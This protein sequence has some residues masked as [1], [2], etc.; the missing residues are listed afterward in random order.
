MGILTRATR[1]LSRRKTRALIVIIA[2]SLALTMLIILPPSITARQELT[3]QAINGLIGS[4]NALKSTVTLSATEIQCG[5]PISFDPSMAIGSSGSTIWLTQPLM[6]DSL[7]ANIS[8]IPDVNNV[9]P[10]LFE[11]ST[12]NRSYGIYGV[13]LDNASF[14]MDPSILPA[15]ITEGRNLQVGDSGVVILDE[16][17]AKNFSIGIS[18]SVTISGRTLTVV[19]IEGLAP[20]GYRAT[21]SLSDAWAIT[22]TSGQAS[23]Y[24]IF[25]DNVDNVNTVVTRIRSIDPKLQ[26]SAGLSQLNTAQPMQD[27]ITE[28]TQAAQTNL[29]QIQGTGLVEISI[30]V[31]ADV[32]I[33]LFIMLYSVRERTKEIGTLKAIGASNTTILGQFIFEGVILSLIAAIVAMA[34]GV[35][36]LPTL[37]SLLLPTP[38]QTGVSISYYP[39]GTMYLGTTSFGQTPFLPGH[40]SNVIAASVTPE[41][42][43]LGLG[44]AVLLGALGS[45]YP[46][47]KAARTKPA[48]AMRYE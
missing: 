27:Q 31:V 10:I 39:N 32:A 21:M 45:L 14:Q 18:D 41:I 43:L 19:G 38:V 2:L 22:N 36:V 11:L 23:A 40:E 9:I 33:I 16:V 42:M 8:S 24:K 1:N 20:Q 34:V 28:L 3:Q 26:V 15:N 35:F 7:Y 44:A 5:Y 25:A 30:A 29:N 12:A 13:P 48:E 37:S 46:A 4:A 47:L 17:T 6:N